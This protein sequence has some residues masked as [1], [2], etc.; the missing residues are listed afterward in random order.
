MRSSLI[1]IIYIKP[2]TVN[3][4]INNKPLF[5]KVHTIYTVKT[6]KIHKFIQQSIMYSTVI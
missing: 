2:I 5:V 6:Y 4:N 1:P 3:K